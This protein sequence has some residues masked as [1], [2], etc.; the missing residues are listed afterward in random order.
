MEIRLTQKSSSHRCIGSTGAPQHATSWRTEHVDTLVGSRRS[1]ASK[2]TVRD[3]SLNDGTASC[4]SS[5]RRTI[6]SASEQEH[7]KLHAI[8]ADLCTVMM[9]ERPSQGTIAQRFTINPEIKCTVHRST[10]ITRALCCLNKNVV[11]EHAAYAVALHGGGGK[12]EPVTVVLRLILVMSCFVVDGRMSRQILRYLRMCGT[13]HRKVRSSLC[14][15]TI[16]NR[17]LLCILGY[18]R[19]S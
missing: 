19:L 13:V 1:S 4:Y 14:H 18:S 17:V 10:G 6:Q 7:N 8:P 3:A 16:S 15:A 12:A 9:N 5:F 2:Y 11:N